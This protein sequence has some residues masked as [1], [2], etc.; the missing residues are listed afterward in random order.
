VT[1]IDAVACVRSSIDIDGVV[2]DTVVDTDVD[3]NDDSGIDSKSMVGL[4]TNGFGDD[5][6]DVNVVDCDVVDVVFLLYFGFSAVRT[7]PSSRFFRCLI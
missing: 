5:I 2:D 1:D 4:A 7:R 3:N 6:I